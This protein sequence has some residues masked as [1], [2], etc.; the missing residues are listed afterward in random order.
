MEKNRSS[1]WH[2]LPIRAMPEPNGEEN[3][4]L[5]PEAYESSNKTG[6]GSLEDYRR[7]V[8]SIE[9]RS[10]KDKTQ[11]FP[12]DQEHH[13]RT[14]LSHSFE[15]ATTASSILKEI[16]SRNVSNPNNAGK[17]RRDR[18]AGVG[19]SIG[20]CIYAEQAVT[21]LRYSLMAACLLHD[22]ENPPFGHFGEKVIGSW[23][24]ENEAKYRPKIP[25]P[26]NPK[27]KPRPTFGM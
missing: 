11:V 16:L 17:A 2:I 12:L 3:K 5:V 26:H 25:M 22:V 27:K 13:V 15:V 6:N 23:F 19:K 18:E 10:L 20:S 8:S 4:Q 21:S 1:W 24:N 7:V 9:L 14:R